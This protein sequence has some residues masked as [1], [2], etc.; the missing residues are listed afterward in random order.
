MR[1]YL[2]YGHDISMITV[3]HCKGIWALQLHIMSLHYQ[4][5]FSLDTLG[6]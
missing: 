5:V 6:K 2:C 1:G 4:W 3:T